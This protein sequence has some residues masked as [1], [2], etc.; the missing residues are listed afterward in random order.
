MLVGFGLRASVIWLGCIFV[1]CARRGRFYGLA[2]H[3]R[4]KS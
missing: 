2:V 3:M 1:S 4:Q